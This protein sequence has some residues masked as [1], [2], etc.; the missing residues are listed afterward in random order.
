MKAGTV[1]R[2]FLLALLL[3]PLWL[4]AAGAPNV[5]SNG[6]PVNASPCLAQLGVERCRELLDED[7]KDLPIRLAVCDGLAAD[8]NIQGAK[9]LL[10]SARRVHARDR[11][12]LNLIDR[13]MSNLDER[14][15]TAEP[16]VPSDD[17][18][19]DY[20][21]LRCVTYKNERTC[22]ELL[23]IEPELPEAHLVLGQ[24][25]LDNGGTN[26]AISHLLIAIKSDTPATANEAKEALDQ[27][28]VARSRELETCF[29]S[30]GS[31][32]LESCQANLITGYEDERQIQNRIGDLHML[33]GR[34]EDAITAYKKMGGGEIGQARSSFATSVQQCEG[35][36]LDACTEA[37]DQGNRLGDFSVLLPGLY[38]QRCRRALTS[39][40]YD[41]ASGH[42][43][44]ALE[45]VDSETGDSL[46]NAL[47]RLRTASDPWREIARSCATAV[48]ENGWTLDNKDCLSIA[49]AN[50]SPELEDYKSRVRGE[51]DALRVQQCRRALQNSD[52]DIAVS[53]CREAANG[54]FLAGTRREITALV[55]RVE[56]PGTE[57]VDLDVVE[58]PP[59]PANEPLQTVAGDYV[60]T[61]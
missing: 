48:T 52:F 7:P 46:K 57:I 50:V 13:A 6:L 53:E 23:A 32:A 16:S 43:E 59:L 25:A 35:G 18:L 40:D 27:A 58:P 42:C 55:D 39:R 56:K 11:P 47:D 4:H 15:Q 54:S 51:L 1:A 30:S 61:F 19:Q 8:G 3:Q 33:A 36:S 29:S 24:I 14:T 45:I 17:V 41:L 5:C 34:T 9:G 26:D 60:V 10:E 49:T 2:S 44:S 37:I 20:M 31:S 28:L 22:R 21:R 12:T 38:E